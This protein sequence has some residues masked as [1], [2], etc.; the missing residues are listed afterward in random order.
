M[1]PEPFHPGASDPGPASARIPFFNSPPV[2]EPAESHAA[3]KASRK[4][5]QEGTTGRWTKEEHK[6]F[7]QALKLYGKNWKKVQEYVG[8]RTTTQARS[9]AQKYFAKLEHSSSNKGDD[10]DGDYIDC[11]AEEE[12][13]SS[14]PQPTP[15]AE[16]QAVAQSAAADLPS[17]E[18][19]PIFVEPN[20][21]KRKRK[22]KGPYL[23][24]KRPIKFTTSAETAV[25]PE[26]VVAAVAI[27]PAVPPIATTTVTIP[28]IPVAAAIPLKKCKLEPAVLDEP[29]V[30]T[31]FHNR[32][33][34]YLGLEDKSVVLESNAWHDKS[35][36]SEPDFEVAPVENIQPLNLDACYRAIHEAQGDSAESGHSKSTGVDLSAGLS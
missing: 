35:C 16:S 11:V 7:L 15:T 1:D 3:R 33:G 9:H 24:G 22:L 13:S 28:L 14:S 2:T 20:S 21:A 23:P 10:E 4:S 12:K 27:P 6:R 8:T 31:P 19:L 34:D 32:P 5:S 17:A 30:N 26:P 18:P 25:A 29:S 36:I